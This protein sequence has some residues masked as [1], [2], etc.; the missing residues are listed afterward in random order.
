M[1]K[2]LELPTSAT[3]LDMGCGTGLVGEFLKEMG[4]S[5]IVGVDASPEMLLKAREKNAYSELRELF[6]GNPE[7]YPEDLRERFDAIA[8]AGVLAEGHCG[9]K[10][11]DEMLLSVKK[12]GFMIWATREEYMSKYGYD[13]KVN[14]LDKEGKWEL[15]K[16]GDFIRYENAKAEHGRFKPSKIVIFAYKKL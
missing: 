1:I 12:G 14:E 3:V 6:L 5:Q 9:T 13:E 4:Y 11:F 8:T 7:A 16:Q 10:L 15:V 2:E